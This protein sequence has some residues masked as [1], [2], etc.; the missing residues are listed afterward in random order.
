MKANPDATAVVSH[1]PRRWHRRGLG[2]T[3]VALDG[4]ASPTRSSPP[5]APANA[6]PSSARPSPAGIL[7]NIESFRRVPGSRRHRQATSLPARRLMRVNPDFD[8]RVRA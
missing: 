6:T 1:A 3:R 5:P 2:L 8:S 7:I 4:S